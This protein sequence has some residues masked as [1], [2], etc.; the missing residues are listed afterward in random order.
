MSLVQPLRVPATDGTLRPVP[1]YSTGRVLGLWA[2]VTLPMGLLAFVVGPLLAA[3]VDLHRGLLH[4]ILMT[5]GMAWQCVL[6][7]LLLRREGE[8]SWPEVKHRIRFTMPADPRTHEP[9]ARLWWWVIPAMAA[10][11]ALG[12][13]AGPLVAAW[14]RATGLAEPAWANIQSLGSPEFVGQWW[15]LA[16]ALVSC[17][18]NYVLG[19]ELFFRGVLLPRMEGAFGRWDWVVNSLLFGLYH[20]HKIWFWPAMILGS[21]GHAWVARRYRSL[22][23]AMVVHG[24]EGVVLIALVTAV[25][26]GWWLP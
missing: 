5:I 24:V 9:R 15:I 12:F 3:Q 20:V 14:G 22:G 11:L 17:A 16:L 25:V 13:A 4:W 18:F 8:L 6:A 23:M 7:L 10:N 26:G 1:Q 19:E 21:L 2:A